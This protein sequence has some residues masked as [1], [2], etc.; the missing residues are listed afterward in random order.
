MNLEIFG[1]ELEVPFIRAFL[2][3]QYPPNLLLPPMQVPEQQTEPTTQY[4]PLA[5]HL[6]SS[7]RT[8]IS[9]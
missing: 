3:L 5:V 2:Q 1:V 7:F 6:F 9:F 8:I 4:P